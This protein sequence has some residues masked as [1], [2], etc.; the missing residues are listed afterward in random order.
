[1]QGNR[2]QGS[3]NLGC[4]MHRGAGDPQKWP[5]VWGS[6][7]LCRK[8]LRELGASWQWEWLW[9]ASDRQLGRGVPAQTTGRL[10][11]ARQGFGEPAPLKPSRS[12]STYTLGSLAW[13]DWEAS[14]SPGAFHW[15]ALGTPGLLQH[16]GGMEGRGDPGTS[17]LRR[18]TAAGAQGP[19]AGT[20][21]E[22]RPGTGQ[23]SLRSP[24]SAPT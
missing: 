13:W 24:H 18:R 21:A 4:W 6:V 16:S 7:S 2:G 5:C 3:T 9:A 22:A 11:P 14:L 8:E 23:G 12:T 17:D 1:M 10:R 19:S 20:C 15:E